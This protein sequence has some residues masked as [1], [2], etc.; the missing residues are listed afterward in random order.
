M[1]KIRNFD[2]LTDH[3]DVDSRRLV[4]TIAE[5]TLE[6]LDDLDHRPDQAR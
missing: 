5:R 4:L 1:R 6:R 3:G 2:R